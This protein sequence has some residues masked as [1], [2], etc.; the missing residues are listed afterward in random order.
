MSGLLV[1]VLMS[2]Y[3]GDQFLCEAVESILRQSLRDL[4]LIVI[5]DGSTDPTARMLDE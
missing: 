2:V 4:E 3:N 5:N 1:S